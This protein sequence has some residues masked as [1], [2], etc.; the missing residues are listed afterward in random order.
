M[1]FDKVPYA[2]NICGIELDFDGHTLPSTISGFQPFHNSIPVDSNF[3]K[4]YFG[5]SSVSFK[6]EPIESTS[7]TAY[8]QKIIFR[9]PSTDEDRA[10][11]IE[12][13]R[14]LKYVKLLLT[15]GASL[16]IGRNDF[17]QN[18]LPTVDFNSTISLTTLEISCLSISPAGFIISDEAIPDG[19]YIPVQLLNLT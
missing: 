4:A 9:F 16:I 6:E 12:M 14:K 13:F 18:V 19:L 2:V 5:K 11:R 15:T 10:I 17:F 3:Q 7:G 8:S 1:L